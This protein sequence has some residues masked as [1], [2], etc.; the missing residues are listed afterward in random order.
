MHCPPL[1]PVYASFMRWLALLG[2]LLASCMAEEDPIDT[3]S[4]SDCRCFETDAGRVEL[5]CDPGEDCGTL[6]LTC[7]SWGSPCE[8][9]E[10]EV[11]NPEVIDCAQE[12]LA[13]GRA[14]TFGYRQNL[15]MGSRFGRFHTDGER[16]FV[17]EGESIDI[18]YSIDPVE[19]G[20][21]R[22]AT[23]IAACSEA[24]GVAQFECLLSAID[25]VEETCTPPC[26]D[27]QCDEAQ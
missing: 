12:L 5:V 21:L 23:E 9:E 18:G 16:A 17:H 6:E 10:S 15:L 11:A 22:D 24:T 3:S 1:A 4:V 2:L 14:G 20:P 27:G 19:A 13:Q 7:F 8:L 25:H 26:Y